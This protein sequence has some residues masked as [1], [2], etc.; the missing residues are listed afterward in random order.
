MCTKCRIAALSIKPCLSLRSGLYPCAFSALRVQRTRSVRVCVCVC[1]CEQGRE[2]CTAG[3]RCEGDPNKW[4]VRYVRGAAVERVRGTQST[5][6]LLPRF[7]D[8]CRLT[9]TPV[10]ERGR[11]QGAQHRLQPPWGLVVATL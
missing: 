3:G 10:V 9:H 7:V 1:V 8:R 4:C 6:C 11:R 5:H 2:Q